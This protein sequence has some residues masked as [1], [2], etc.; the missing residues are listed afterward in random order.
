MPTLPALFLRFEITINTF[1]KQPGFAE[2]GLRLFLAD[3]PNIAVIIDLTLIKPLMKGARKLTR[4]NS[5]FDEFFVEERNRLSVFGK[6]V[7]RAC[8]S[9]R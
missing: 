1:Y 6:M 7:S 8:P 3:C 5:R 9:R 2:N 4:K